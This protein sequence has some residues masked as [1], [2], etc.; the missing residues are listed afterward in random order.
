[1][2]WLQRIFNCDKTQDISIT[3]DKALNTLVYGSRFFASY[4]RVTYCQKWSDFPWLKLMGIFGAASFIR[5]YAK[6]I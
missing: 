1:M 2:R 5:T 6:N 4:T 3:P